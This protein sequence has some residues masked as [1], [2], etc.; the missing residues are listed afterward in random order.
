MLKYLNY[1]PKILMPTKNPA[2]RIWQGF[3]ALLC[4]FCFPGNRAFVK[5]SRLIALVKNRLASCPMQAAAQVAGICPHHKT[6]IRPEWHD[7][8]ESRKANQALATRLTTRHIHYGHVGDHGI[9]SFP[10]KQKN[11]NPH[12]YQY[13]FFLPL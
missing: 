3:C 5:K 10:A 11:T 1:Q 12:N 7:F 4:R 13:H 8:N 9:L 2:K 6:A